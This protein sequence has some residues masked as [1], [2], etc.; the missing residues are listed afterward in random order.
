MPAKQAIGNPALGDEYCLL[1]I[2]LQFHCSRGLEQGEDDDDDDDDDEREVT[3]IDTTPLSRLVIW[4]LN[5][6]SKSIGM[7]NTPQ[8]PKLLLS[9]RIKDN[10]RLNVFLIWK[11][12]RY[13]NKNYLL[14]LLT[15][16]LFHIPICILG[17]FLYLCR[18]RRRRR[19]WCRLCKDLGELLQ[20]LT[21]T[22]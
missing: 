5:K 13:L 7:E 21:I 16:S 11:V 22:L 17:K 9:W 18:W 3:E 10:R 14:L 19:A 6:F 1:S 12:A 15:K 2:P 4:A 8:A 20:R